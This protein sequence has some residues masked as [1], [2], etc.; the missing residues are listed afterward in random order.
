MIIE[1][2]FRVHA[3]LAVAWQYLSDLPGLVPLLP[4]CDA[5]EAAGEGQYR[6][7]AH[8][9]VGPIKTRVEGTLS[10][11]DAV[12]GEALT[13]RVEGQDRLTGSHVRAVAE[14]RLMPVAAGETEVRYAADVIVS[15]R[16][17][18][19][20]Q[21]IMRATMATMLADFVR[22]LTARVAGANVEPSGRGVPSVKASRMEG[23]D[24]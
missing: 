7:V 16:L 18:T 12:A 6:V 13:L 20:G 22:R 14:F 5:V 11:V 17:G 10:V 24:E 2:E 9:K 8:A 23:R 21:G 4:G 1:G 15:G 19:I 3:P